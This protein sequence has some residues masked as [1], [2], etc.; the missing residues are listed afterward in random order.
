M[1]ASLGRGYN[2]G[3]HKES[4]LRG[5]EVLFLDLGTDYTYVFMV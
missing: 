3:K 2:S 1:V 5:S 4:F